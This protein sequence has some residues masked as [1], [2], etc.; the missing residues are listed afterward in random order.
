MATNQLKSILIIDSQDSI[1]NAFKRALSGFSCQVDSAISEEEG[2]EKIKNNTYQLIFLVLDRAGINSV[3][4]LT[5]IRKRCLDVPIYVVTAFFQD[6][7][8]ELKQLIYEGLNFELINQPVDFDQILT[9][10]KG[11]L[12][13]TEEY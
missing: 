5:E 12:C 8:E 11:V 3:A 4:I 7:S 6:Y 13:G 10:V 1:R 2:L 9:V